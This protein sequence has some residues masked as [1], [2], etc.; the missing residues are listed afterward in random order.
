MKKIES[1]TFDL[2]KAT[3]AIL[4]VIAVSMLS[5]LVHIKI[6]LIVGIILMASGVRFILWERKK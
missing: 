3:G 6:L 2:A 5:I 4:L 1:I